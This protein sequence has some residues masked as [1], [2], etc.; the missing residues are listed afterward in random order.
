MAELVGCLSRSPFEIVELHNDRRNSY[1]WSL[2]VYRRWME[3]KAE[4]LAQ[5]DPRRRA[6]CRSKL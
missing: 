3:R 6:S 5:A 1:L 4:V 2:G